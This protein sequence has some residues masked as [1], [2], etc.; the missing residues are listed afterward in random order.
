MLQALALLVAVS[1]PSDLATKLAEAIANEDSSTAINVYVGTFPSNVR[2]EIPLPTGTLIGASQLQRDNGP[3]G[4]VRA[5]TYFYE[6]AGS[7]VDVESSYQRELLRDG[8][9]AANTQRLQARFST[10]GGFNVEETQSLPR[11]LYCNSD[12]TASI[13]E[14]MPASPPQ[15]VVVSYTRGVEAGAACT[16][17]AMMSSAT[18]A[19][20]PPLPTINAPPNVTM[21][22][23]QAP[24]FMAASASEV[25]VT[26]K[27]SIAPL[28]DGFA[29]QITAAG[30]TS[31]SP[32]QSATAYAQTFHMMSGGSTYELLLTVVDSGKPG[33]YNARLSVSDSDVSQGNF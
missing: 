33:T 23:P 6:V 22:T 16:I 28:A 30:W 19:S 27:I 32:A 14:H 2:P 9:I 15:L 7:G 8:W 12:R 3:F 26:G 1:A 18:R 31:D 24:F 4:V 25:S 20:P 5:E 11:H 13:E 29:K 17:M 10:A 21:R